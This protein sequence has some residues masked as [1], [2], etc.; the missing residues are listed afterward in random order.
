MSAASVVSSRHFLLVGVLEG[1][2]LPPYRFSGVRVTAVSGHRVEQLPEVAL[3]AVARAA[4]PHLEE[5]LL[6][7][8]VGDGVAAG[9]AS[10]Q[11]AHLRFVAAHEFH[12]GTLVAQRCE[13]HQVVV[14]RRAWLRSD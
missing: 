5:G 14:G 4:V 2:P 7:Q 3:G 8:L 12:E 1:Q 11:R 9:Q 6:R 10:A 13:P